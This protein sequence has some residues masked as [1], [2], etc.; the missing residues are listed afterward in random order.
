MF[1]TEFLS[2]KYFNFY[3]AL[4]K[5]K[6]LSPILFVS[7]CSALNIDHLARNGI[8][9]TQCLSTSVCSPSH[10]ITLTGK[11][12]YRNYTIWG[13]IE[14][15]HIDFSRNPYSDVQC[16]IIRLT[17]QYFYI[18]TFFYETPIHS[19]LRPVCF[20]CKHM[21]CCLSKSSK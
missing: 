20:L 3:S 1:Y 14:N 4:M 8:R 19:F 17:Q 13:E 15:G 7:F 16:W 6:P 5:Q 21:Y 2:T 12:N 10:F 9:F 18:Q 11:Y